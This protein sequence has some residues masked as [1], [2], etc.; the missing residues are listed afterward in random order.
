[1]PLFL[2]ELEPGA[3]DRE[4]ASRD[5]DRLA[6]SVQEHGGEGLEATVTGDHRQAFVVASAD[7]VEPV[8]DAAR[9]SGLTVHGPDPVRLVGATEDEVRAAR[10]GARFLVEWDFPTGL[11]MD[12]YLERKKAR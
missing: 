4:S 2:L 12:A 5:L 3:A 7:A 1:M 10:G 8:A 6:A 9:A 11:T